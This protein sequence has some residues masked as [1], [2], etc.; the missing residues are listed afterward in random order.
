MLEPD[1]LHGF[2]NPN[3]RGLVGGE[4]GH[5]GRGA[6]DGGVYGRGSAVVAG[7]GLARVRSAG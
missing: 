2:D 7:G 5:G 6:Q 4:G 3:I 1:V